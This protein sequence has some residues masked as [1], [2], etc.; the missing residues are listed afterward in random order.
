[1]RQK[2]TKPKKKPTEASK[3]HQPRLKLDMRF[4]EAVKALVTTK[5]PKA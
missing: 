4:D 1:M 3:K 5:P 2:P